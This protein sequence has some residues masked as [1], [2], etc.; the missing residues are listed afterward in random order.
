[1]RSLS[2]RIIV[3]AVTALGLAAGWVLF[4]PSTEV[5][6]TSVAPVDS[7]SPPGAAPTNPAKARTTMGRTPFDAAPILPDRQTLE[8]ARQER[9]QRLGYPIPQQYIHM[10]YDEL[11]QRVN[12]GD[13]YALLQMADRYAAEWDVI[14]YEQHAFATDHPV[15][16]AQG[17]MV[18]A[19]RTGGWALTHVQV[20]RSIEQGDLATAYA[21][22]TLAREANA[23]PT[24]AYQRDSALARMTEAERQQGRMKAQEL[25]VQFGLASAPATPA[26]Q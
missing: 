22:D 16:V 19:V 14:Q 1:M 5:E 20:A 24:F 23:P 6:A 12:I 3:M 4:A 9:M 7:P 21:W 2:N 15:D 17:L 26:V 13:P 11:R 25:R 18:T 8:S 10:T